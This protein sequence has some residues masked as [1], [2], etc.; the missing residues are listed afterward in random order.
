MQTDEFGLSRK[1]LV[2]LRSYLLLPF[3]AD[4]IWLVGDEM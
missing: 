2:V 3:M 1:A 4:T